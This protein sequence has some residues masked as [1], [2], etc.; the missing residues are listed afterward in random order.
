MRYLLK[1]TNIPYT[2]ALLVIGLI[3]GFIE[4]Y[5]PS[6]QN[7]SLLSD[8]VTSVS[9]IDPHL[10][11]FLFLPTLIFESA[12]AIE[13][14]LFRRTFTQ[15]SLL[16]V[17]GLILSTLLTAVMVKYLFPWDW[18]WP[19]AL[20]FGALISATDPVAV[21]ALLKE[22]SSRKRLETL[23]EGESLLNDGTAIV[24]FTLFYT[25][26][27]VTNSS[28]FDLLSVSL[29]FLWVVSLG[30]IIGLLLGW[31]VMC[32]GTGT[33]AGTYCSSK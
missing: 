25:M 2:V 20:M 31:I 29:E 6:E 13:S 22:I 15:I 11:L 19:L 27:T 17:P 3:V 23:I 26:I 24:M 4:R 32:C 12:F 9:T 28:S 21:V 30:L 7:S 14:H 10:I 1:N 16:A 8:I 33:G 5:L 18:S